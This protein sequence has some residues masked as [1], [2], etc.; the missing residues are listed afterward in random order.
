M[1][2]GSIGRQTLAKGP[3][4]A[5]GGHLRSAFA[6]PLSSL[7]ETARKLLLAAKEIIASEG[8]GA[9]TLNTVG[10]RAGENKA[11]I[12]YYFEN[13]AGLISAVLDSVIHDEYLASQERLKDVAAP[14]RG[15]RLIEEM[16]RLDAATTEFQI[17]F[18]LLPHVVRDE[19]LR[20]R[21]ALLYQWYWSLKLEWLGLAGES[22]TLEDP[23]LLGLSQLLSA[24][25]DG[26]AI[27]VAI[28]P[29]LDLTHPYRVLARMFEASLPGLVGDKPAEGRVAG[30]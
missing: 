17:F 4:G 20:S 19:L 2:N 24:I 5:R 30:S 15:Q 6:D 27:Q 1:S 10:T 21:L 26:L 22:G 29:E 8:F 7:P 25:I 23:D 18:E 14:E 13:K 9:L 3:Q 16:R 11:M 28:D 12:A